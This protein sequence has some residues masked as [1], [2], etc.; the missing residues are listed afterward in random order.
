[1]KQIKVI[2]ERS[3]DMFSSYAENVDGI[4]GGG[5]TV[6]EAN[7]SSVAAINLFKKYNTTE[8]IPDILK[9]DYEL[10]TSIL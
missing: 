9:G 4:Y 3:S 7:D 10:V 1:M 5:E 6:Q 2:I 8:Y